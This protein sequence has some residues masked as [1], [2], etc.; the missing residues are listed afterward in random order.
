MNGG[1]HVLDTC[2]A[3]TERQDEDDTD[4]C[5]EAR[6]GDEA[7]RFQTGANLQGAEAE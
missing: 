2:V 3:L 6:P 1:A 4:D 7:R 5:G